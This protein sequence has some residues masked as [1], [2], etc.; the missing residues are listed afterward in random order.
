[1]A[2]TFDFESEP[3]LQVDACP[4][5]FKFGELHVDIVI[6]YTIRLCAGKASVLGELKKKKVF[7]AKDTGHETRLSTPCSAVLL[8][9]LR[10]VLGS[11]DLVS[12]SICTDLHQTD[13]VC[14]IPHV[15]P[16]AKNAWSWLDKFEA[17]SNEL[18]EKSKGHHS[19]R[20][21]RSQLWHDLFPPEL[22]DLHSIFAFHFCLPILFVHWVCL[23][24]TFSL[25]HHI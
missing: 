6:W 22:R 16:S 9:S 2:Q 12:P 24:R 3:V 13:G 20:R 21:S 18:F 5:K 19:G 10:R 11:L 8:G 4:E 15:Y 17:L 23:A 25:A 1:M 14:M 7:L